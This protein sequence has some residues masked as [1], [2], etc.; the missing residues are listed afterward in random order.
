MKQRIGLLLILSAVL[1]IS[2]TLH[3]DTS[4][5]AYGTYWEGDDT[6]KGGGLRLKKTFLGF[7]AVEGRGGYVEFSDTNTEVYPLDVSINARLP[8]MISPYAGIGAGYYYISSDLPGLD[9]SSGYFGQIGVEATF[10]W[11]GAMAEIR[12]HDLDGSY[13]DGRSV[14][15]GLLVKW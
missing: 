6:G 15:I 5:T 2:S 1:S 9:N 4:L 13:F 14:N 7:G 10:A 12:F 3:A 11:F 8:F